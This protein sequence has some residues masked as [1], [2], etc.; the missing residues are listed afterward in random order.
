MPSELQRVAQGLVDVLDELPRVVDYLQ[1]TAEKCRENAAYIGGMTSNPNARLATM[2]LDEAAR[3]CDEAAHYASLAPQRARA[4][5]EQMVSGACTAEPRSRSVSGD[6]SPP[7]MDSRRG[8]GTTE[9]QARR[10]PEAAEPA[11]D[12][13]SELPDDFDPHAREI[14]ERLPVRVRKDKTRGIWVDP[15][16]NEQD[17]ISGVDEDNEEAE[18]FIIE[19]GLDIAP[20]DVTLGSHVEVKFAMRMRRLGLTNEK[21]VINNRPCE[22][23][24]SCDENLEQSS[25]TEPS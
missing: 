25:Q 4:W 6:A 21:I 8:G 19:E 17:L 3:R 24:Y 23:P 20:G 15:G 16:G 18:R 14:L 5:A 11:K 22:G 2:Q 12:Q 10:A 7:A 13:S 9:P 1:R